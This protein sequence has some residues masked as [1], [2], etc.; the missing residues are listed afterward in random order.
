MSKTQ[1]SI[2]TRYVRPTDTKNPRISVTDN[3][4]RS[5][6]DWKEGRGVGENHRLAA[7]AW[8]DVHSPGATVTT[9]GL[10]FGFGDFYWTWEF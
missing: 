7:Q 10:A 4:R 6:F 9:P 1:E 5:E 8:L 3:H 2:R